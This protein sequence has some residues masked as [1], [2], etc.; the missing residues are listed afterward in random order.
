M[1]KKISAPT[2]SA[3]TASGDTPVARKQSLLERLGLK[4]PAPESRLS[5]QPTVPPALEPLH[6]FRHEPGQD[7]IVTV[8]T[9]RQGREQAD[10]VVDLLLHARSSVRSASL[11]ASLY[12]SYREINVLDT[13][14]PGQRTTLLVHLLHDLRAKGRI[15][16]PQF[17]TGMKAAERVARLL[18]LTDPDIADEH[19]KAFG[20]ELRAGVQ[21]RS[22]AM[23]ALDCDS[24]MARLDDPA[25]WVGLMALFPH[26]RHGAD[27]IYEKAEQA[28][29]ALADRMERHGFIPPAVADR[30][31][32]RAPDLVLACKKDNRLRF[33][34]SDG[35]PDPLRTA[36]L[37]Q[38]RET[39]LAR[40]GPDPA[41]RK[42]LIKD[43]ERIFVRHDH[44]GS[45]SAMHA[46]YG[47]A[48]VSMLNDRDEAMRLLDQLRAL[49]A[50][51]RPAR[52]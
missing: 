11:P 51:P 6:G 31:R 49:A 4:K 36:L 9:C 39:V 35:Q 40:I 1:H 18:E 42:Q 15:D 30:I 48:L 46:R 29:I 20:D 41:L 45:L 38:A 25:G 22:L 37:T 47:E 16:N 50:G 21:V 13:V 3:T 17:V 44:S 23:A 5:T 24:L 26:D 32:T 27:Q 14:P 34:R 52:T 8:L 43:L 7:P 12:A 10:Q 28:T 2:A 33:P 19:D